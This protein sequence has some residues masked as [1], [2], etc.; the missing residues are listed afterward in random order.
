MP[1]VSVIIATY[2]RPQVLRRAIESVR[3]STTADWEVV[4][5]GDACTD[6]TE[7]VVRR[8]GDR[9]IRFSNLERN[10]GEQSGPNNAG[11]VQSTDS[12]PS[13]LINAVDRAYDYVDPDHYRLPVESPEVPYRFPNAPAPA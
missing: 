8:F 7:A 12:A 9:R 5:V 2:Q 3:A 4:V 10:F 6:D 13:V 1:G 11:G